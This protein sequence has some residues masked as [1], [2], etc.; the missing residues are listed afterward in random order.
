MMDVY[1]TSPADALG[2][3]ER[4]S[5]GNE[6]VCAT[7]QPEE[8]VAYHEIA[9]QV[10]L[11]SRPEVDLSHK[12]VLRYPHDQAP[13]SESE[14]FRRFRPF[15]DF[16]T[17]S[18]VISNFLIAASPS[19]EQK[20][21]NESAWGIFVDPERGDHDID[22]MLQT[23]FFREKVPFR[24][25]TKAIDSLIESVPTSGVGGVITVMT[26]KHKKDVV[27]FVY[28]SL[29]YGL[30][31]EDLNNPQLRILAS[32][33]LTSREV[34]MHR[35]LLIEETALT[36]YAQKV[37]EVVA[38]IFNRR[39]LIL[40][41][42]DKMILDGASAEQIARKCLEHCDAD[43]AFSWVLKCD[44][45]V[46]YEL[47][48]HLALLWFEFGELEKAR[49]VIFSIPEGYKGREKCLGQLAIAY[50]GW[51]MSDRPLAQILDKMADG[52]E[53]NAVLLFAR[54]F[55]GNKEKYCP[56]PDYLQDLEEVWD[57]LETDLELDDEE[58]EDDQDTERAQLQSVISSNT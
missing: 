53:K 28:D 5:E 57:V 14:L 50:L 56:H 6:F 58:L 27:D 11:R 33:L 9:K 34:K 51:R 1:I 29:P 25:F 3:F 45:S 49:E 26:A 40:K 47:F 41:A 31:G 39:D 4:L 35:V 37:E 19:L 30:P 12:V 7:A 13:K 15:E 20:E 24:L 55:T 54:S 10:L 46:R 21:P 8:F 32:P 22:I 23:I 16:D 48:K 18:D 17:K 44:E 43:R 36:A 2:A 42:L 52:D 38:N